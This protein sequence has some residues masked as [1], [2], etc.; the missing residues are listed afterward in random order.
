MQSSEYILFYGGHTVFPLHIVS[1]QFWYVKSMHFY[2]TLYMLIFYT[3]T[4]AHEH[5]LNAEKME[6]EATGWL[7][8]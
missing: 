3:H 1:V 7:W 6:S 5:F 8:K 2:C 4:P